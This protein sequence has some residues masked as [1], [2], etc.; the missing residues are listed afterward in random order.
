[1]VFFYKGGIP[2][3]SKTNFIHTK[4]HKNHTFA[5]FIHINPGD[6]GELLNGTRKINHETAMILGSACK[7]DPRL[8]LQIQDKNELLRLGKIK[9][10][11]YKKY[12][13]DN[14]VNAGA[15]QI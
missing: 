4:R 8:S 13:I 2:C 6:F 14:L 10:N 5:G 11:A 7:T 9:R 1:L 15:K 3:G 12:S